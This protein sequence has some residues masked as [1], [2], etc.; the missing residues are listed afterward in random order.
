MQQ[1]GPVPLGERLHVKAICAD[2]NRAKRQSLVKVEHGQPRVVCRPHI[3][4]HLLAPGAEGLDKIVDDRIERRLA[5]TALEDFKRDAVGLEDSFGREQHPLR[6]DIVIA[7]PDAARKPWNDIAG[8]R[9]RVV[10]DEA[11]GLKA[12]GGIRPG[13]T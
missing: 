12:P 13:S 1:T 2:Q 6:T 8:N 5:V 3:A 7:Q 10:H 4:R 9:K 11:S